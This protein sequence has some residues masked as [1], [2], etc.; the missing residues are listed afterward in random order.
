MARVYFRSWASRGNKS[1]IIFA[2]TEYSAYLCRVKRE[3]TTSR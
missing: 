1:A 3:T 2:Q